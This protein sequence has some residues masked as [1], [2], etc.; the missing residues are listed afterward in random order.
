MLFE[1][2]RSLEHV[3]EKLESIAE[4]QA[5]ATDRLIDAIEKMGGSKPGS[6]GSKE[7]AETF[8]SFSKD[9]VSIVKALEKFSK[10]QGAGEKFLDFLRGFDKIDF[11]KIKEGG[12]ALKS[13]ASGLAMFG[14]AL[15]AGTALFAIAAIGSLIIVPMIIGYALLFNEIGQASKEIDAG[16][17]TLGW[18]GLGLV[19][20]GLGLF[21]VKELAGG[22]FEEFAK[23]SIIVL[24]GMAA[25]SLAFYFVGQFAKPI[26]EGAKALAWSGLALVSLA[27]GIA[28]FQFFKVDIGSVLV[29]AAAIALTGIAFALVGIASV[30]IEE[31]ALALAIA[32]VSLMVLSLGLASFRLLGMNFS[33]ALSIAGVVTA[34]GLVFAGAGFVSPFILL[35]AAAL[36]VAGV[37]LITLAGGLAVMNAVY[38]KAMTGLFAPSAADPKQTNL[39]LVIGSVVSAFYINPIKSAFMLAGAAALI[40]ASVALITLAG[41]VLAFNYAF[42]SAKDDV[43]A[44]SS[45]DP[46]MTNMDVAVTGIVNAFN[47]NPIKSAFM[48]VGAAALIVASVAMITMTGGLLAF[49][50]AYKKTTELFAPS[51]MDPKLSNFEHMMNSLAGGLILGPIRLIG[52][53]AAIPAWLAA[54]F[55][56]MSIGAGVSRFAQLVKQNINIETID[57]MIT[58]VL[59]TVLDVFTNIGDGKSVNWDS[60]KKGI[61]SVSDVGNLLTGIAEGVAK[62]AEL[63]F[64]IYD[65]DGKVTGYFTVA[66]TQFEQVS[67]NMKLII[68]A[69]AGTLVEIG[70]TDGET[71]WFSKSAGE[72]GAAAIRGIGGD[73]VGLADFVQKVANLTFPIYDKKTGKQTGVVRMDTKLLGTNGPVAV[74]IRRM[75]EAVT[76]V[77]AEIGS[78]KAAKSGWF[79]DSDIEKGKQAIAGVSGDLNGIAQMVQSV[80]QV[81][82]ID[83]VEKN[84]RRIMLVIPEALVAAAQYLSANKSKIG[85][86][87]DIGKSFGEILDK[88]TESADPIDKLAKSFESI[89]KS[90]GSF[91]KTFQNMKFSAV[92]T[93]D[94]LIGSLVTFSKVDP[95][96]FDTLGNRAQELYKFVYEKNVAP[97]AE[98]QATP[99]T[100]GPVIVS[101]PGEKP[102][103]ASKPSKADAAQA[104]T[105]AQLQ[106]MFTDMSTNMANLAGSM[107]RIE[108]ILSGTLKVEKI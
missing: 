40:V 104:E 54:G 83:T 67:N 15:V 9:I 52:L 85:P 7:S 72:K 62:M 71:S 44:A 91:S 11:K 105:M 69:V 30:P 86:S 101:P 49:N 45:Q 16:A 94:N 76:G 5:A 35:G 48:L 78:G 59:T 18:M 88:M 8:K 24:A 4:T 98:K 79:S 89:S 103:A 20:F 65:K 61:S 6:K 55:A 77:L 70:E 64:P 108:G 74:N 84:I 12:E 25:F 73:L 93:F 32:G 68:K 60:V 102:V 80:A 87:A 95:K 21:A 2:A 37:S 41:G 33:E 38:S 107:K 51:S 106:Q 81:K 19:A 66:D 31:G 97:A 17:K 42:K 22:S 56:L 1:S 14:L 39:D 90:M 3:S 26:E 96:A 28:A 46:K 47:I 92:K 23:G 34:V 63:K 53:Y 58:K 75:I 82:D 29:A 100:P 43:L 99:A 50:Y 57:G 10:V 36:L 27:V 13:M